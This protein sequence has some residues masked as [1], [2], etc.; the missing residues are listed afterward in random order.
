MIV[1]VGLLLVS[2]V[3]AYICIQPED[4]ESVKE[5][6]GNMNLKALENDIEKGITPEGFRLKLKYFFKC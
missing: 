6:K 2:F 3:S 5:L 1:L 4:N